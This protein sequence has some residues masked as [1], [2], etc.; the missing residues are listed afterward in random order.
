[1]SDKPKPFTYVA[2][3]MPTFPKAALT[4]INMANKPTVPPP[5]PP[6]SGGG[7]PIP[8]GGQPTPVI[9]PAPPS[10]PPSKGK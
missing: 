5:P 3:G 4:R 9:I 10:P 2:D 6:G 1:M 8:G 7:R